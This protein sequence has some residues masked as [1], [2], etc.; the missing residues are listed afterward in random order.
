MYRSGQSSSLH[1][2]IPL[3]APHPDSSLICAAAI[4]WLLMQG[5]GKPGREELKHETKKQGN[6]EEQD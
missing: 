4:D 3:F 5:R 1:G 6:K 2:R